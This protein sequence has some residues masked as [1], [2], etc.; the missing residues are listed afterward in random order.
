MS[1]REAI[2]QRARR[3]LADV[4]AG[5]PADDVPVVRAEPSR[6]LTLEQVVS[7]F[8]ER[9][10]DYRAT[11]ERISADQVAGAVRAALAERTAPGTARLLVPR[12]LPDGLVPTG[13]EVGI[14]VGIE[15]VLDGPDV[16][17]AELDRCDAVLTTAR[18]AVA[19]TGTVVLDHG[20]GQGRRAASLIPDLHLCLVREH[21]V[22]HGVPEAIAE[23]DPL[24][25]QTWISGPS[26]TSDIELDRVEG[27][28][29]P[30]TLHV[31]IAAD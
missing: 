23:L 20:P 9:V 24:R 14:D 19:E 5:D 7:L 31:L 15:V 26:A 30:R 25:P 11:V 21:Q 17:I 16:P 3:A 27:V 8:A 2:L 22:R 4:P 10:A 18:V 12:D 29:G 1:S 13:D 6:L 28:H